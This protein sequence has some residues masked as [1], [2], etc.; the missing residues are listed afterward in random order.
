MPR[1]AR[2]RTRGSPIADLIFD[3][4]GRDR[5]DRNGT[6]RLR[7]NLPPP[8]GTL[9]V[10]AGISERAA[11]IGYADREQLREWMWDGA[12]GEVSSRASS[13]RLVP[14]RSGGAA[15]LAVVGG[16]LAAAEAVAQEAF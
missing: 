12:G 2:P 3:G 11:W 6:E 1:G 10:V 5:T 8:S 4:S 7:R 9:A 14:A 16:D 13:S 15:G